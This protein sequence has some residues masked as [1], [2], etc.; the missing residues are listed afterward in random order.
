MLPAFIKYI[1]AS[2]V[3]SLSHTCC[4]NYVV[5]TVSLFKVLVFALMP[6]VN[7]K[8]FL[9]ERVPGLFQHHSHHNH[10]SRTACFAA[11]Y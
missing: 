10:V 2:L 7:L 9:L 8:M 5:S 11:C 4:F 1:F 3:H 6:S